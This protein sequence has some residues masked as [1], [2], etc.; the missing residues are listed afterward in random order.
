MAAALPELQ[1]EFDALFIAPFASHRW[2]SYR[3]R[4]HWADLEGW[5]DSIA[6]PLSAIASTGGCEYVYPRIDWYFATI[7]DPPGLLVRLLEFHAGLANGVE[8]LSPAT[9]AE[10]ADLAFMRSVVV[11]MR[12]LIERACVVEHV[13]W[14]VERP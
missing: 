5:Q 9:I 6:G 13:R 3:G 11:R 14:E 10:A 8:R 7:S 12:E 1:K 4:A 2:A